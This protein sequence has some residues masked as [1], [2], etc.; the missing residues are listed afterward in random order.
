LLLFSEVADASRI[1]SV[2]WQSKS[3]K[4]V[5]LLIDCKYGSFKALLDIILNLSVPAF[6]E[7]KR[8]GDGPGAPLS[9]EMCGF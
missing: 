1:G 3:R 9:V 8:E 6:V 4:I 2:I 5:G 7:V